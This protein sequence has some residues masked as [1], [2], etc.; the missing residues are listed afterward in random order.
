MFLSLIQNFNTADWLNP[1]VTVESV[2]SVITEYWFK[3]W[4]LGSVPIR[5]NV[6]PNPNPNPEP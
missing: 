4:L 3:F 2:W 6:N 1:E 5:W